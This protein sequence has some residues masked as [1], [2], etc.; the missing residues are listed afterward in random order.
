MI[1]TIK[2]IDSLKQSRNKLQV[3]YRVY[4]E[5]QNISTVKKEWAK[6]DVVPQF[7]NYPRWKN[8]LKDDVTVDADS[9]P[10]LIK[11]VVEPKEEKKEVKINQNTLFN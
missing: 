10:S 11:S 5:M 7:R 3:F 6:T 1:G 4:F 9:F 2:K 8:L